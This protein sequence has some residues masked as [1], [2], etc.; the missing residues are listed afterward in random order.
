M[1]AFDSNV[2]YNKLWS[3][4]QTE[5]RI[6]DASRYIGSFPYNAKESYQV[7]EENFR[8]CKEERKLL[9]LFDANKMNEIVDMS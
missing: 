9:F 1:N 8:Y 4:D 2:L 6:R 5:A 3:L 7:W